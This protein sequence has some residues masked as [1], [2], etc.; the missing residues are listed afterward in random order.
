[1]L[2]ANNQPLHTVPLSYLAKGSNQASFSV[3]WQK[4]VDEIT[5]CHA[6]ASGIAARPKNALFKSLCVFA[7]TVARELVGK[8]QKSPACRVVSHELPTMENWRDYFVGY[9]AT[10]KT[11][12]WDGLQPTLPLLVP[13]ETT[14]VPA[15]AASVEE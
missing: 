8:K 14:E 9:D 7:F 4:L 10:L 1:L 11:Q 13:G 3:E 5:A 15:L 6:I 12:V 2:D